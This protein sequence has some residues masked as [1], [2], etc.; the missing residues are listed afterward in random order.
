MVV[1]VF[2][3]KNWRYTIGLVVLVILVFVSLLFLGL[4]LASL[5]KPIG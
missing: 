4:G 3:E 5:P 2:F 1:G